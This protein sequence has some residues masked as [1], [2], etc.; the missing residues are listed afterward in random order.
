[1]SDQKVSIIHWFRR[2]LRI[3]DNTALSAAA[4]SGI[5]VVPAYFLSD[6][7]SVHSWTGP[8]RQHFLCESLKS[9]AL[10]LETLGG[11]LIIRQGRVVSELRKLITESRAVAVHFNTDPDP[12]P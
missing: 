1:M 7:R 3:A 8:N 2:D 6:W 4:Q 12:F 5:P 10:N 9:L 11:R